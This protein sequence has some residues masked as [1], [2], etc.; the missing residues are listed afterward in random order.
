MRGIHGFPKD[1]RIIRSCRDAP[2]KKNMVEASL[3][4]GL[5]ENGQTWPKRIGVIVAMF[6]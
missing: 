5:K 2:G 6:V 3:H 4:M 1:A